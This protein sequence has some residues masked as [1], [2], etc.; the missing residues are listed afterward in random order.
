MRQDLEHALEG[1]SESFVDIEVYLIVFSEVQ[2]ISD[3]AINLGVSILKS[4]EEVIGYYIQHIGAF[5]I[6]TPSL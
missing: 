5:P 1:L 3:A 4:I 2:S 6:V